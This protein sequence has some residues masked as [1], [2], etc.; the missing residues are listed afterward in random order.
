MKNLVYLMAIA[1]L[2]LGLYAYDTKADNASLQKTLHAQYTNSLAGAS[3][4]LSNL[5]DS[6]SQS[7]LF[8]DEAALN[9][10]LDNIWRVSN[11]LRSDIS[12][13][14]LT[15]EVSN[16]WIRYIGNIGEEA[17]LAAETGDYKSWQKRCLSLIQI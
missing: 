15:R 3:E 16:D 12:S 6:V 9:N 14:P 11:E 1:I 2:A 8:Q 4:K 13:L 10:E 17:K 7:L 5:Q